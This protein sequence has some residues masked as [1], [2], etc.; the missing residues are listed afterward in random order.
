MRHKGSILMVVF[1]LFL[2]L[3]APVWA[4]LLQTAD[5]L[6]ESYAQ[7]VL[8]YYNVSPGFLSFAVFADTSFQTGASPIHLFFFDNGC[9]FVRDVTVNLTK[10][11]VELLQLSTD[12]RLQGVIPLEGVIFADS[13]AFNTATI[14]IGPVP[15]PAYLAYIIQV[16]VGE[17]TLTRIDSIPFSHGPP[18]VP[19]NLI[20]AHWTRY[21]SW[22][23]IAATFGDGVAGVTGELRTTLTFFTALGNVTGLG[24]NTPPYNNLLS[25]LT[26]YGFPRVGGWVTKGVGIELIAYDADEHQLGSAH[27]NPDCF[28]RLRLG[29]PKLFPFLGTVGAEVELGHVLSFATSGAGSG[30]PCANNKCGFSGFQETVVEGGSSSKFDLIF[31]GYLHH[32]NHPTP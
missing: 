7:H 8:P 23:T 31:S 24:A 6:E 18:V 28:L 15:G 30:G 13:G 1:A 4:G 9:N 17:G 3:V 10:N 26:F 21:D 25:M 12:P 19:G 29:N 22:N 14:P 11:D 27:I 32:S 20:P 2:G 16:N 5:P